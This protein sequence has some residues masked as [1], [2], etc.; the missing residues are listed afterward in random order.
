MDIKKA[1]ILLLFVSVIGNIFQFF[2]N[3]SNRPQRVTKV[4]SH[5][6]QKRPQHENKLRSVFPEKVTSEAI[7]RPLGKR[8]GLKNT[9]MK[10]AITDDDAPSYEEVSHKTTRDIEAFIINKLNFNS[11]EAS[12]IF[13]IIK[14]SEK[15][16]EASISEKRKKLKNKYD[17]YYGYMFDPHD[18]ILMGK[19]KL[20]ARELIKKFL[21][22]KKFELFLQFVQDYNHGK[23]SES[24]V[25]IEI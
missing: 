1:S 22:R 9:N 6:T 13:Q 17:E 23:Y 5:V 8:E 14:D 12:K 20:E 11:Q 10:E 25:P 15:K 18:Y 7:A 21:G 2:S 3:D 16:F 24:F 19:S 4:G